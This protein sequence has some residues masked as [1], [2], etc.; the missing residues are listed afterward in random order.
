[1]I[2]KPDNVVTLLLVEDSPTDS[3]LI[4]KMLSKADGNIFKV[5]SSSS[6]SGALK[7]L[8]KD[9]FDITLLDLNLPDSTGL[10]TL[11]RL[12]KKHPDTP[13]VVI[14]GISD[15][16]I[17]F[18][19][20]TMGAQ[21]YLVKGH[22]DKWLLQ[23]TI[24]DVVHLKRF[25]IKQRQHAEDL[26]RNKKMK[27]LLC[28]R[29][30]SKLL[31]CNGSLDGIFRCVPE[32][33]SSAWQDS[34]ATCVRI[35]CEGGAMFKTKNFRKTDRRVSSDIVADRKIM[36][37]LE[38]YHLRKK[39]DLNGGA[40]KSKEEQK[41]LDIFAAQ[42]SEITDHFLI[43]KELNE[44]RNVLMDKQIALEQKNIDLM[45]ILSQVDTKAKLVEENVLSNIE[46]V[47]VPYIDKVR[48]IGKSKEQCEKCLSQCNLLEECLKKLTSTFTK[49]L[50]T[51]GNKLSARELG[52]CHMVK[53]G[54]SNKEI[55]RLASL[56]SHTVERH[57]RNIRKKLGVTNMNVNLAAYLQEL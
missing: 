57:R 52:I 43:K 27:A 37:T 10:N 48:L 46:R 41:I 29:E 5:T 3:K 21:E 20:E 11:H 53:E 8:K 47:A 39:Q 36:G 33:V 44:A 9:S 56:S 2:A 49:K 35:V 28:I 45:D 14:S 30:M 17:G 42:L 1:M 18:Q 25:K 16:V 38:V 32:L 22:Y 6:L 24:R 34:K 26:D 54:L 13:I 12:I 55:A 23:K 7:I 19:A 4:Q 15:Q 50:S 31:K 40:S 51:N